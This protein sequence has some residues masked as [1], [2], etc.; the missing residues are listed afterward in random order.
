MLNYLPPFLRKSSYYQQI[1]G[2]E[3]GQ[4]DDLTTAQAGLKA[5]L[6]VDTST[7]ALAICERELGI[8]IDLSKP[9]DERR[10][11]IK[12]KMRGTG[13]IGAA[14][15]KLVVDSWTNGEVEVDFNGSIQIT[16]TSV[17]GS[18]PNIQDVYDAVEEIKPAH[19]AVLY[20][21]RYLL[22]NEVHQIMKINEIQT[23][24]LTDFAPFI[25][26]T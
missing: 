22:I 13:R 19:L 21:F 7:W 23:R 12:S 8:T 2:A 20:A 26:V 4:F 1:L 6:S 14:L 25:P 18:P 16:F 15:I 10:S 3:G 5:Q 24:P 11:V 17:L 9:A